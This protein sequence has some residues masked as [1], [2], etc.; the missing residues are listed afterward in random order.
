VRSHD[1]SGEK[2]Q[3]VT[4]SRREAGERAVMA[5]AVATASPY[6]GWSA[7]LLDEGTTHASTGCSAIPKATA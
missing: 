2:H 7:A 4:S 3:L 6:P 5:L 1:L